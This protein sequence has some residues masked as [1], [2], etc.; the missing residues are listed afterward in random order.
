[1]EVGEK[2]SPRAC[3]QVEG[4]PESTWVRG[5]NGVHMQ[6]SAWGTAKVMCSGLK[7]ARTQQ[8]SGGTQT[9]L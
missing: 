8:T 2:T 5:G 9:D 7:W 3:R 1:M 6:W 4:G